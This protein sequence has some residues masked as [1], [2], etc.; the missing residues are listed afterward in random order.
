V[1][2]HGT[3]SPRRPRDIVARQK[4]SAIFISK[5][6]DGEGRRSGHGLV[7]LFP[8]TFLSCFR[9]LITI[10]PFPHNLSAVCVVS[11]MFIVE[12]W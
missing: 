5:N 2:H 3:P 1:H 10:V 8:D 7:R 11:C 12:H 4:R 6:E 9:S